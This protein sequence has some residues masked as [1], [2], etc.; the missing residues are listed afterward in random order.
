MNARGWIIA[1][2]LALAGGMAAGSSAQPAASAPRVVIARDAP[3]VVELFTAQGCAGCPEAN[4]AV[5]RAAET[6]GVIALTY[7]VD[8]WD[9]LGWSDTFARPEFVE[10]Q[11]AYRQALK[12]RSVSTP[13]V[14][15]DG[16]RQ[17]SGARSIELT[18]A[19]REEAERRIFPPEI[20]FRATGDRVGVGSGRAPRGG[21]EVIAVIYRPGAQVVTVEGGDNR[22]QAVRHVNVVRDVVRLGDWAGRPVL[23][24]LPSGLEP[25]EAVAVMVQAKADRRILNAATR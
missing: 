10:R 15:V 22:G 25:G 18:D 20:E 1:A 5:E 17:I 4:R 12:L 6:P 7:G 13:Q 2:G 21:A 23:F 14:V 19:I 16:R 11:R 8:Y 3:V 9:Y 24:G